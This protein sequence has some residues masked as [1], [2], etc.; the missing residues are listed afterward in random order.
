MILVVEHL[1]V[2]RSGRTILHGVELAISAGEVVGIIG[3]NGCGKSTLLGAIAGVLPPADGRVIVAGAS[4]WGTNAQ[5]K[6]ARGAIGYV[7]EGADPPGFLLGQELWSL[8][9]TAR[10]APPPSQAL[11]DALGLAELATVRLERMS[12]GQR[13][14]A[15]LGAALIGAPPLLVLDE[16]DNGLDRA[17][18]A[19]LI[20]LVRAHAA[21][22]GACAI[23]T[24]D[25]ELLA[26]LGARSFELA[27]IQRA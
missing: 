25:R 7:P 9:E 13:R 14:R 5:R 26:A 1:A 8:C 21:A 12:L 15:C 16:P 19:A 6:A 23:A 22:G 17:R 27:M 18:T 11:I 3:A 2:R 10:G 4:V 20:E 24:H